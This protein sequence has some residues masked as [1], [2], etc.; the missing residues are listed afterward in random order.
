[1]ENKTNK[2]IELANNKEYLILRQIVYKNDTYYVASEI[3]NDGEEFDKDLTVLKQTEEDGK[4]YVNIVNN[5][6]IIKIIMEH[7]S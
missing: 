2:V 3:S 1:M 6:E 5:P 7:I 4:I